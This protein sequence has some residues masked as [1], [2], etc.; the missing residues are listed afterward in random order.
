MTEQKF[1]Q[2][3][4]SKNYELP[5][6]E[7]LSRDE[8]HDSNFVN[9]RSILESDE[10]RNS[11]AAIPLILGKDTKGENVIVD[12]AAAPHILMAGS[13]GSG[14]SVCMDTMI[15]SLL[16]RFS[17]DQLKMIMVDPIPVELERYHSLPHLAVPMIHDVDISLSVLLRLIEEIERRYTI[18]AKAQC[19]NIAEYNSSSRKETMPRLVVMISELANL[20]RSA[21]PSGF[22]S[23]IAKIAQ[24]GRAAGVHLIIVTQCPA[25]DVITGI[26]K[27]NL[28]TVIAFK[29]AS[30]GNSRLILDT[31]G[32]EKLH[33]GG[34][35]LF[36]RPGDTLKRARGAMTNDSDLRKVIDFVSA[37]ASPQYDEQV[38]NK[39]HL[40]ESAPPP[41][42]PVWMKKY[43]QPDD[44]PLTAAALSL[45]LIARRCSAL[46]L[47]TN[48]K[49]SYD[50]AVELLD[51]F[52]KRG[53]IEHIVSHRYKILLQPEADDEEKQNDE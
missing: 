33:R 20:M 6:L 18:L 27:A 35:I 40:I 52:E 5:P 9:I 4:T 21:C 15:M 32:A 25:R 44:P 12:L 30:A 28:P 23:F 24:K 41:E 43:I 2:E 48:L 8:D 42:L 51:L 14:K 10:W 26:I 50:Q 53:V 39:Q 22:E 1:E 47:Q 7:L 34:D 11:K 31:A 46:F 29:V 13:T 45:I 3:K 16:Y 49:T 19:R 36:R 38:L 17:P 37:Q